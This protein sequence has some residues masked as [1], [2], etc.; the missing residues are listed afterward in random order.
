MS[1]IIFYLDNQS[2]EKLFYELIQNAKIAVVQFGA[3]WC[4]PCRKLS[5][6]LE[7]NLPKESEI[8]NS[9]LKPTNYTKPED[10]KDKIIF[11]K[12]DVDGLGELADKYNVNSMPHTIFLKNGVEKEIFIGANSNSIIQ[13]VIFLL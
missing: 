12:I 13:K 8:F 9:I 5:K 7:D 10:I 4:S 1:Q 2:Q 6:D 11:V 3:K